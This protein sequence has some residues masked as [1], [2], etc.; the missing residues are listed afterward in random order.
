MKNGASFKRMIS[1]LLAGIFFG[2]EYTVYA[3][4]GR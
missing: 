4:S 3:G 2:A 1:A